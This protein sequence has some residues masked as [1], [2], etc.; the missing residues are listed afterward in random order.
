[1]VLCCKRSQVKQYPNSWHTYLTPFNSLDLP[2]PSIYGGTV[3]L[4]GAPLS[5]HAKLTD[6]MAI[7]LYTLYSLQLEVAVM[8]DHHVTLSTLLSESDTSSLDASPLSTT[9]TT[10]TT[11]EGGLW[12]YGLLGW[13][14]GKRGGKTTATGEKEIH[15]EKPQTPKRRLSMLAMKNST[16]KPA[17]NKLALPLD[18]SDP[19]YYQQMRLGLERACI[20]TSPSCIFVTP[21][22]VTVLENEEENMNTMKMIISNGQQQQ[23]QK[24]QRSS[25][26][27]AVRSKLTS[28]ARRSSSI[29]SLGPADQQRKS[30]TTAS[31]SDTVTLPQSITAYNMLRIPKPIL[32]G[33]NKIGMAQLYLDSASIDAFIH[34]Q[35]LVLNY[36]SYPIGC[37]DRPCLGPI[38]CTIHYFHFDDRSPHSDQTLE[39]TLNRWLEESTHP[40]KNHLEKLACCNN[41]TVPPPFMRRNTTTESSSQDHNPVTLPSGGGGDGSE[42]QSSTTTTTI[43]TALH[44][45]KQPLQDHV[46]CF[47]HG[48]SRINVYFTSST[49]P[50][51][52]PLQQQDD[53]LTC[54]LLCTLCDAR[55]QARPISPSTAYFSFAKYLELCFYSTRF[56]ADTTLCAHVKSPTAIARCFGRP[57]TSAEI[58]FVKE[59]IHVYRLTGSPLQ[60][61]QP[62]PP[63]SNSVSPR[64]SRSTMDKWILREGRAIEDL[65]KQLHRHLAGLCASHSATRTRQ[66]QHQW[67]SDRLLLLDTLKKASLN[68]FRRFFAMQASTIVDDLNRWQVDVNGDEDGLFTWKARPDYMNTDINATIHCF[69][70]SAVMVRELEPTSIIAYTLR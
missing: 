34:H 48:S 61:V 69:P 41:L 21:S 40:C 43:E 1:M 9:A 2:L 3:R 33:T 54:W 11:T 67:E 27:T 14:L 8:R 35:Q 31:S 64:I 57:S 17:D 5:L 12:K 55:T 59:D 10:T 22:I 45:C 32:T 6:I 68:D 13:V 56:T 25:D 18:A 20:S 52:Q 53:G 29:L 16:K 19:H 70:D 15:S 23:K 46:L 26:Q 49:S 30:T 4:Y 38:L 47:S 24:Q 65:F 51:D 50:P 36:T 7:S 37:P 60:V 44:G 58:R 66:H 62:P 42:E 39:T 28:L 63:P